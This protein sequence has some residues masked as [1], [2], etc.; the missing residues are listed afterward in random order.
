MP[1]SLRFATKRTPPQRGRI[2]VALDTGGPVSAHDELVA[3]MQSLQAVNAKLNGV[4]PNSLSDAEHKAW[5]K[6]LNQV[7][8]AI[9]RVRHSLLA[10][11]TAEF[12]AQMSSIQDAAARLEQTLVQLNQAVAIIDAVAGA[13]GV[14]EKIITLGR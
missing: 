12:E 6:Q 4:D 7:D 14:I 10:G 3:V 5:S 13:L 8:L 9:A 11:I 2:S 1:S